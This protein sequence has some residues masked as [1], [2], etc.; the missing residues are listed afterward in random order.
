MISRE[1]LT[2]V[3]ALVVAG[4]LAAAC[5]STATSTSASQ[6]PDGPIGTV[7]VPRCEFADQLTHGVSFTHATDVQQLDAHCMVGRLGLLTHR[8]SGS[9]YELSS[10]SMART[11]PRSLERSY[12]VDPT[13]GDVAFVDL[14]RPSSAFVRLNSVGE[15]LSRVEV[16]LPH[17]RAVDIDGSWTFADVC[18]S[19]DELVVI[20]GAR[21]LRTDLVLLSGDRA[22]LVVQSCGYVDVLQF[23]TKTGGYISR[24]ILSEIEPMFAVPITT[25]IDAAEG[26]ISVV[27]STTETPGDPKK[28]SYWSSADRSAEIITSRSFSLPNTDVVPFA[29]RECGSFAILAGA[30]KQQEDLGPNDS[31]SD[32]I[33]IA[34]LDLKKGAITKMRAIDVDKDDHAFAAACDRE[35]G[36]IIVAGTVGRHFVDTGSWDGGGKAIVVRLDADLEER[37]RLVFGGERLAVARRVM[38]GK[39][40]MVVTGTWDGTPNNHLPDE[41]HWSRAF[42]A[43]LPR[44]EF[45]RMPTEAHP[46]R[47]I[48]DVLTP[49]R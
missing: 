6:S 22:A 31:F 30:Q 33:W 28:I 41:E 15:E 48:G 14:S 35:S 5:G 26:E 38:L 42:F 2:S 11:Y 27:T 4:S 25:F 49:K 36:D 1:V 32:D 20:K 8:A 16:M 40:N 43:V 17:V 21:N 34:T 3:F 9:T 47:A 13:S 24:T 29:F 10:Q 18:S 12:A 45:A 23:S 44:R 46:I 7:A 39:E 19:R 37:E